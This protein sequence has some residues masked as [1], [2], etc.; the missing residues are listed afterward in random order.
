MECLLSKVIFKSEPSFIY[1][2]SAQWR[3][4]P[5]IV[6]VKRESRSAEISLHISMDVGGHQM[7]GGGCL[8]S[9][10]LLP[11]LPIVLSEDLP[12]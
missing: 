6:P 3:S 1:Q 9:V 2:G 8:R 11:E 5:S 4:F 10:S 12:E 7:L